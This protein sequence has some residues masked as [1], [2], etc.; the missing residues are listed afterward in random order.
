[1]FIDVLVIP[2]VNSLEGSPHT[3]VVA[4]LKGALNVLCFEVQL[5][6]LEDQL[7]HG[8]LYTHRQELVGVKL[9]VRSL[10]GG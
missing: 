2:V 6:L 3:K 10:S 8:S 4:G 7:T 9:L 1:M 5:D